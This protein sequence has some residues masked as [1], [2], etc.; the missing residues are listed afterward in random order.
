MSELK[1]LFWN[2]CATSEISN[3]LNSNGFNSLKF[4]WYPLYAKYSLRYDGVYRYKNDE[5]LAYSQH[6]TNNNNTAFNQIGLTERNNE[7]I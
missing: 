4:L 5:T 6:V 7:R 3:N 1:R 2:V